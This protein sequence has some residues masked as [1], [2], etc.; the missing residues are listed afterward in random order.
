MK[1]SFIILLLLTISSTFSQ[2]K[3][4]LISQTKIDTTLSFNHSRHL[5]MRKDLHNDYNKLFEQVLDQKQK[6][7]DS[8]LNTM[9]WIS[10]IFG[11]ILTIIVF[12]FGFV[13]YN[14]IKNIEKDI[15]KKF[16]LLEKN[17]DEK[18]DNIVNRLT[19]LKYEKDVT[20]IKEKITNLELFAENA[21]DSFS[22]KRGKT[23][24]E[25]RQEVNSSHKFNNPFDKN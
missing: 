2:A 4:G 17:L 22:V 20:G 24:P 6:H 19:S 16:S 21:R 8:T 14:S 9:M 10:G 13:G 11:I 12:V 5:Y 15:D 1:L 3:I 7:Y 18:I 23:K 25:I